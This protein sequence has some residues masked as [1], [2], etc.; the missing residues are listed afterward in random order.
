MFGKE[1][2]LNDCLGRFSSQTTSRGEEVERAVES[3]YLVFHG[4]PEPAAGKSVIAK[5][6]LILEQNADR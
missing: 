2:K 5:S 6:A 4:H 1:L 3:F